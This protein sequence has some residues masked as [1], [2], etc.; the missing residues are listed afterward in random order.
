MVKEFSGSSCKWIEIRPRSGLFDLDLIGVWR[1]R[2]LLYFLV[3]RE[4]KI[5]Y[6]QAV[7]GVGW[8]IFQPVLALVIFV[9]IFGYFARLP[10]NGTP[11]PLFVFTAV[12]PW[13]YFAEAVRRSGAGL[14]GDA[15]LIRKIYFPR[16]VIPLAMVLAPV[17]DFLISSLILLILLAWYGVMPTIY[18]V[19]VPVFLLI[20]VMLALSVGLWLGPLNVRFRDIMHTL[21]FLIQIWMYASPIVYPLNMVPERWRLLYSLNPMVGVIE[22]L[23]WALLGR[24]TPNLIAIGLSAAFI[25]VALTGGL[26]FFR[27]MERSFADVI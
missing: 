22:G 10:S 11:Y 5:R 20:S 19:S 8:A 27:R 9:A 16:L 13:T 17:I 25:S 2:E 12:L 24:G 7:F 15:E 26:V 23:R 18:V 6:K 14:V 21:P 3:W 1:Y 4:L